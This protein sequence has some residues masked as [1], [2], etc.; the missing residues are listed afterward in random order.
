MGWK[1]KKK[2]VVF[3]FKKLNSEQKDLF[4]FPPP[5]VTL[6]MKEKE[7]GVIN[8]TTRDKRF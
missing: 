3:A 6:S 4:F 2:T 5:D 8:A 7:R 1:H